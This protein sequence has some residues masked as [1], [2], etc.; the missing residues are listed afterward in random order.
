[1]Y[2]PVTWFGYVASLNKD[3]QGIIG[4]TTV[5]EL[6]HLIDG[7]SGLTL[8]K[9]FMGDINNSKPLTNYGAC[10]GSPNCSKQVEGWGEAVAGWVYGIDYA[11]NL[12]LQGPSGNVTNQQL[13]TDQ[14]ALI[15]SLLGAK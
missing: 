15:S 1:V 14:A 10:A 9:A 8:S 5:H 6:A 12:S 3:T 2:W 11:N 13:I 7:G 4:S